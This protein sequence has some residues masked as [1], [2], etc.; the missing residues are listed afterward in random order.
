MRRWGRTGVSI[1]MQPSRQALGWTPGR[2]RSNRQDVWG[3]SGVPGL[4]GRVSLCSL[5]LGFAWAPERQDTVLTLKLREARFCRVRHCPICQWRRSLM[6]LARFQTALPQVLAQHPTARF[7]FLTL[8]Q[9]NVSIGQLRVTL[10]Q[11]GK[12][13][14][15][16]S[17]RKVFRV[18]L[19]W[20][21]TTEVTRSKDGKAYPHFHVLLMVA[22]N[23]FTKHYVAHPQWVEM[24]RVA[25]RVEYSP[26]VDIRRVKSASL[27]KDGIM[28][29]VR[30]TLK[31]SVKPADMK[32]DALWF[33]ELTRQLHKLRFIASGGVLKGFKRRSPKKTCSCSA[34]LNQV[35]KKL[36]CISTGS[37]RGSVISGRGRSRFDRNAGEQDQ[38]GA[39]ETAA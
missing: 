12:A 7:V 2:C 1:G 37:T 19:G 9:E 35:A 5:W 6:W 34:T 26:I 13:W 8:T 21:R 30:E 25:L 33:L 29:A 15:R 36:R 38:F 16:L 4:G 22:A 11:M 31:Y 27:R 32:V 20:I 28:P 23:Y 24:W 3:A 14:E 18:V 17:Q 39:E 10:H